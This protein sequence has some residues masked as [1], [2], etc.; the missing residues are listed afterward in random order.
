MGVGDLASLRAESAVTGYEAFSYVLAEPP[1]SDGEQTYPNWIYGRYLDLPEDLPQRVI[2]LAHGL[3]DEIDDPYEKALVI[4]RYLR[5][6]EYTLELPPPPPDQDVADYFLFDLKKGYCDYYA[7][8]MVVLAR[9]VGLPARMAVGYASGAYE[10]ESAS[11]QVTRGDAHSW[12]EI[13]FVGTGWVPFEPTAARP[14][15]DMNFPEEFSPLQPLAEDDAYLFEDT[16]KASRRFALW[17]VVIGLS[18]ALPL[19]LLLIGFGG[20]FWVWM[21]LRRL[22]QH[23]SFDLLRALYDRLLQVGQGY[24]IPISKTRTPNEFREA[25]S[26]AFHVRRQR[27]FPAQESW[28]TYTASLSKCTDRIITSYSQTQY[29]PTAIE[30]PTLDSLLI[31]W[32]QAY[33]VLWLLRLVRGQGEG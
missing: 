25:F 15:I 21:D 29:S 6:Y 27:V 26:T 3:T 31:G 32:V 4:Q 23:D 18:L 14:G 24:Q 30:R 33:V 28:Q 5:T 20:L 13:Y 19:I 17:Q 2:D 7:T 22:R 10:P 9:S 16:D 8:A 1:L 11:Y 12:V